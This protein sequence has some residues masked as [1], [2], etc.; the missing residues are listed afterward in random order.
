MANQEYCLSLSPAM[1]LVHDLD[2]REQFGRNPH[3]GWVF[4]ARAG[5]AVKDI[6]GEYARASSSFCSNSA[7][8]FSGFPT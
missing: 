3:T 5:G 1:R 7:L 4:F 8:S 6:G 2:Q